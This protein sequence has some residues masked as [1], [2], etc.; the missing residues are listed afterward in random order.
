MNNAIK[1]EKVYET[2]RLS[3]KQR[4]EGVIGDFIND[5]TFEG[6][7]YKTKTEFWSERIKEIDA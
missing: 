1:W 6:R 5:L 3:R 7:I 2:K 4:L